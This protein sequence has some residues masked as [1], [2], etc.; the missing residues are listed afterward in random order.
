MIM[1][2]YKTMAHVCQ[3]GMHCTAISKIFG[4][5]V[6][7]LA[8]VCPNLA[9]L[10]L[11]YGR[12]DIKSTGNPRATL[13]GA[14]REFR[15]DQKLNDGQKTVDIEIGP[16]EQGDRARE[17]YPIT[18]LTQLRFQEGRLVERKLEVNEP[19]NNKK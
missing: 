17:M 1:V 3:G 19:Y 11:I 10:A 14:F 16:A 15:N 18:D 2:I 5:M 7:F 12:E 4:G 8:F 6:G 9:S 13:R